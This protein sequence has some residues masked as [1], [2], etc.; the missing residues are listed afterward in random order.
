[1]RLLLIGLIAFVTSVASGLLGL[2][3]AVRVG[4]GMWYQILVRV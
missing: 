2:G 1:M 4:A 3:G